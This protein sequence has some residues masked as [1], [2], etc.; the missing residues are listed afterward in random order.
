MRGYSGIPDGWKS[1]IPD[2]A[3]STF[4]YTHSS[5]DDICQSTLARALTLVRRAGGQVGETDVTI[6]LQAPSPAPLEQWDMGIPASR[7]R[8]D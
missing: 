1:G 6:P 8:V 7:V 5:L 2:I 3:R 4:A